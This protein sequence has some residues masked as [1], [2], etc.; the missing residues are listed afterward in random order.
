MVDSISRILVPIDGSEAALAGLRFAE[1]L[2]SASEAS[3]LILHVLDKTM[4]ELLRV[5]EIRED[6]G[7][8]TSEELESLARRHVS[9][10]Y[11][12]AAKMVLDYDAIGEILG[13]TRNQVATLLYR[14]KRRL[15][16]QLEPD[17]SA[18]PRP[19]AIRIVSRGSA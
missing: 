7:G 19:A 3:L 15:R 14:A 5:D 9:D 6:F 12:E 16:E 10:P 4:L 17:A 1:T 2:A 13:V 8:L 11:F 18:T